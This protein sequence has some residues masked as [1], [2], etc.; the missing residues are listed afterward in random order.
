MTFSPTVARRHLVSVDPVLAKV[1]RTVGPYRP[2]PRR[3][4]SHFEALARS[5]VYQQLSG[6]AAGTIYSRFTALYP[7]RRLVPELVLAT[8]EEELRSVGLSRQKVVYVRDLAERVSTGRLPLQR[9]STMPDELLIERLTAVK[10]IGRWTAQMFLMFRLARPDVLPDLDLG[11]QNAI[12]GAYSLPRRPTPAE[13]VEIGTP[14]RPYASVACWYL[15][16]SLEI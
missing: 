11:I 2:V 14:W 9:A 1:I 15:W 10:G 8:A 3:A 5:I 13:V 16:R 7:R 4:G 6:R 12:R